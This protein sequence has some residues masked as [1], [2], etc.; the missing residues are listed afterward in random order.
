MDGCPAALLGDMCR[1]RQPCLPRMQ[2]PPTHP[3]L[4][5]HLYSYRC[6]TGCMRGWLLFQ[7]RVLV[8][9]T[10]AATCM[11]V[12]TGAHVHRTQANE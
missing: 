3:V 9:P 7:L 10:C 1:G 2:A 4:I 6:C 12:Q 8:A 11:H 5:T